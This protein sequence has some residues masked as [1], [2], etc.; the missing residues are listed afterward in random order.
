MV[1]KTVLP[2]VVF[3]VFPWLTRLANSFLRGEGRG[4]FAVPGASC[5]AF[6]PR[7]KPLSVLLRAA[8]VFSVAHPRWLP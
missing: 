5:L 2:S 6:K 3:R 1:L 4:R 7:L 8:S